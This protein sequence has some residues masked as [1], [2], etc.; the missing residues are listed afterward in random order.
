MSDP[1]LALAEAEGALEVAI[2]EVLQTHQLD[3]LRTCFNEWQRAL[4]EDANREWAIM[5]HECA[6]EGVR[7]IAL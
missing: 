6:R 1:A 7:E 5:E 4:T 3:R 2:Q